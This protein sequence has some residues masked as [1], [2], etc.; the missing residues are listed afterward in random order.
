MSQMSQTLSNSQKRKG[1]LVK[2]YLFAAFCAL[3]L[4]GFVIFAIINKKDD[5]KVV[6]KPKTET[7]RPT[8]IRAVT[9]EPQ[10]KKAQKTSGLIEMNVIGKFKD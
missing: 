10:E 8:E 5:T 2:L 4:A 6:E 1:T 9:V 7:V 3:G